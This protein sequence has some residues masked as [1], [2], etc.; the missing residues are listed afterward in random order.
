MNRPTDYELMD[1]YR[2][3]WQDSYSSTPNSQATV[4]AAQWARYLLNVLAAD[5]R[6]QGDAE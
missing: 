1:L 3:W 4:V 2:K 5:D 6:E